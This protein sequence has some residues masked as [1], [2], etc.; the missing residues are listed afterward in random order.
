MC[1]KTFRGYRIIKNKYRYTYID[2]HVYTVLNVSLVFAV[3][4]Y[5]HTPKQIPNYATGSAMIS[6]L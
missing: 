2:K 5:N 4:P 3:W 1:Y 6:Y